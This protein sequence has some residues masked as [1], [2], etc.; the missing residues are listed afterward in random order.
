VA[1]IANREIHHTNNPM[2]LTTQDKSQKII[3]SCPRISISTM[4]RSGN[5]PKPRKQTSRTDASGNDETTRASQIV[6]SSDTGESAVRPIGEATQER[7]SASPSVVEQDSKGWQSQAPSHERATGSS[8]KWVD[9]RSTG[10]QHNVTSSTG[11]AATDERK[12]SS[13]RRSK[14]KRQR[15]SQNDAATRSV[16]QSSSEAENEEDPT[17]TTAQGQM[18][19]NPSLTYAQAVAAA[20]AEYNRRN[21]ARARKRAKTLLL[22]LQQEVHHL[23]QHVH[24]LKVMNETLQS[25]LR[26]L[27]EQSALLVRN[28]QVMDSTATDTASSG[29]PAVA[30]PTPTIAPVA[31]L[32]VP[33]PVQP[34]P[35]ANPSADL[36][37]QFFLAS[38]ALYQAQQPPPPPPASFARS[39]QLPI[40]AAPA[41]P[42]QQPFPWFNIPATPAA[43]VMPPQPPSLPPAGLPSAFLN[44]MTQ[45]T[46]GS[47]AAQAAPPS[48]N[49]D[50]A[51]S[52]NADDENEPCNVKRAPDE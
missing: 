9:R 44:W 22:D 16:K 35:A 14:E 52:S 24:T 25:T 36:L 43:T 47:Q 51:R 32:P 18:R 17:L 3:C 15:Q 45:A 41:P 38:A 19:I 49:D 7:S 26:G 34:P 1:G 2:Q 12:P 37:L 8:S 28:Q 13:G 23:S 39:F 46:T 42:P 31:A 48:T 30:A 20:K 10:Q 27:K 21:A 4:K 40:I 11:S 50:A 6:D 5:D 33:P 29:E